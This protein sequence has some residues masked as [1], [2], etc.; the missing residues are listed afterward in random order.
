M[1]VK[2]DI[3]FVNLEDYENYVFVLDN[4]NIKH[5]DS[6]DDM[7]IVLYEGKDKTIYNGEFY[8]VRKLAQNNFNFVSNA[9]DLD[10][11]EC[12]VVFLGTEFDSD[13]YQD[14]M[15]MKLIVAEYAKVTNNV[16]LLCAHFF[17]IEDDSVLYPHFH[18]MYQRNSIS[19]RD[20]VR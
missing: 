16:V 11:F 15:E 10:S 4:K 12:D 20:F 17:E 2:S 5:H 18:L 3:E 19:F 8:N 14:Y 9:K 7:E 6:F 13:W 1:V